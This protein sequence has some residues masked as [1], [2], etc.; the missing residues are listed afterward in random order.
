M[1]MKL[2]G[3]QSAAVRNTVKEFKRADRAKVIMPCGTGK[4]LVGVHIV[5]KMTPKRSLIVAPSL[6]LVKQLIDTYAEQGGLQRVMVVCSDDSTAKE[7]R[8]K[9]EIPGVT[10]DATLIASELR[11]RSGIMVFST[12][13]SSPKIAAAF[14]DGNLPAFDL[15]V[16]DEA[17]HMAGGSKIFTTALDDDR[18]KIR[19]RLFMTATPRVATQSAKDQATE[20][21]YEF[22]SMDDE[23]Q[24]GREAFYM[25]FNTAIDGDHLTDY[26]V[27][28]FVVKESEI[29]SMVDSDEDA[30]ETAKRV[31][32]IR[33]MQE[34]DI[35]K[36]LAYHRSVRQMN[37]FADIGLRKTFDAFK[38][39]DQVTGSLWSGALDGSDPVSVRRSTLNH[40]AGLNGDSRAVLN[41]C[42]V[43]QE[44][45]D[46]P[47]VDAVCLIEPRTQPVD[48]V[49]IVGRAI[50]KSANK[51]IATIILPVFM[52]KGVEED[53]ET[54]IKSSDFAPVW[55]VIAAIRSHDDR[56]QGWVSSAGSFSGAASK[57]HIKF[58]I[59]LPSGIQGKF[60]EAIESRIVSR[61]AKSMPLTEE[62]ILQLMQE[63]QEKTGIWPSYKNYDTTVGGTWCAI[64]SLLDRGGRGLPGGTSLAEL[65]RKITGEQYSR[66]F[67]QLS[68]ECIWKWMQE[69]KEMN[70]KYPVQNERSECPDGSKWIAINAS[71]RQGSRG[72]PGGSSLQILRIK[73]TGES[74]KILSEEAIWKWMQDYFVNYGDWP[75]SNSKDRVEGMT[76][77]AVNKSMKKGR[78]GLVAGSSLMKLRERMMRDSLPVFTED[79][80]SE[81][82][83]EHFNKHQIW[84]SVDTVIDPPFKTWRQIDDSLIHGRC[85]LPGGSSIAKLRKQRFQVS[86]N[87]T[88]IPPME[89][90]P[91]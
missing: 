17:H 25:S 62:L 86:R 77:D 80:I 18:I 83:L 38:E 54:F 58:N 82:M 78:W 4:S 68:E 61:F 70:G 53:V 45:V 87:K 91:A 36:V 39:S 88:T 46:C 69:Y 19:K 1:K 33:A 2:Y 6:A 55:D 63:Y 9:F 79:M 31:A 35:R 51:K 16:F 43:L 59:N 64:N 81:W 85:G 48:I 72:L 23:T 47:A 7:A 42:K 27:A 60:Y 12:Y 3:F 10:T 44:G 90:T 37:W 49:Q 40:F 75:R 28:I 66:K 14:A 29:Q 74:Q 5:K 41:N 8:E 71:L 65:R 84:P 24:F 13:Q 57:S 15:A 76:W 11:K 73:M 56:V 21:G 50:R 67:E 20:D 26:Q 32:L 34:H 22:A 89:S 52:P 30:K